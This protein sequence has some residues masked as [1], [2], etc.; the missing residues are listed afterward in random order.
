[1]MKLLVLKV[2]IPFK[3]SIVVVPPLLQEENVVADHHH[4]PIPTTLHSTNDQTIV[5]DISNLQPF[6]T[7]L[8]TQIL[9]ISSSEQPIPQ[10]QGG[11]A[12]KSGGTMLF[13]ENARR[14]SEGEE[15]ISVTTPQNEEENVLVRYTPKGKQ[16]LY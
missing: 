7:T 14:V 12:N 2:F 11:A 13:E 15:Q 9:L 16:T 6:S 5:T 8:S 1:M 10:Q 3:N 4:L